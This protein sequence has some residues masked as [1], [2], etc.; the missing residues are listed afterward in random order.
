MRLFFALWPSPAAAERLARVATDAAAR[1]GGKPTRLETLHLTLAFLGEVAD[2]NVP[3][4]V[5]LVS[6]LRAEPIELRIDQP[7]YWRRNCLFWA[8]CHDTL[9]PLETLVAELR[10]RL[11]AAGFTVSNGERP[12]TPH[13]TLVRKIPE[14]PLNAA[15]PA[16]GPIEWRCSDFVLVRSQLSEKGPSYEPLARFALTENRNS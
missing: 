1:L 8:G 11:G 13:V 4:L 3:R 5:D 7:G 15:L 12:F 9:A 16:I 10:Q 2:E 6:N 14:I